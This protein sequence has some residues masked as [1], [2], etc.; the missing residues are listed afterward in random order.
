[1]KLIDQDADTSNRKGLTHRKW[2][3]WT[4]GC[5]QTVSDRNERIE[6]LPPDL[7][8]SVR[9][10]PPC[11]QRQQETAADGKLLLRAASCKTL[12][13]LIASQEVLSKLH[14]PGCL[15]NIRMIASTASFPRTGWV[16]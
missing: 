9:R 15:S 16:P 10:K 6:L 13:A 5:V 3:D 14:R 1:M 7:Q 8:I 2:H 4:L 12:G 11:L